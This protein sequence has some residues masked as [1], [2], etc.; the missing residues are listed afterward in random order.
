[1]TRTTLTIHSLAALAALALSA[2]PLP[3][4]ERAG[5]DPEGPRLAPPPPPPLSRVIERHADELGLDAVTLDRVRALSEEGRARAGEL[6]DEL[7]TTR[8]QLHALME[9][10][11]PDEAA[12]TRLAERAG[13]LRTEL[14]VGRLRADL[15]VRELLTDE[16]RRALLGLRP[17]RPAG[18]PPNRGG[19]PGPRSPAR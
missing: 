7:R 8:E 1:M 10:E 12:T 5:A 15:A 2:A 14:D 19:R 17:E 6:H 9:S 18:R 4:A 11:D 13:A 16:Q 3:A